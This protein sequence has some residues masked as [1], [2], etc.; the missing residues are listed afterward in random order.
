MTA[1]PKQLKKTKDYSVGGNIYFAT[2]RV[3]QSGQ[4]LCGSSDFGVYEVD[5]TAEKPAPV[6][7]N[8]KHESYVTAIAF[9]ASQ[10]RV[11]SGSYDGRL[12]WWD[13]EKKEFLMSRPAHDKWIRAA[14][15]SPDE[16]LL[17]SVGD[18]MACH[19]WNAT[20]GER[21]HTFRDHSEQTPH[22]YPSMLFAVAFTPDGQFMAT[23]D[24]TGQIVVRDLHSGN[25]ATRL[26][27]PKMY[28][29]DPRARRHSIGGIRSLA[30]SADGKRLAAG[31][32]GKI[33]NIDHLGGPSRIEIFD[34]QAGTRTA[35]I[36]DGQLKGLVE[37]MQFAPDGSW[38]MSAGGDHGGFV[39]FWNA[40]DGKL[41]HQQK[42]PMHV[43]A[44][45]F[46]ESFETLYTVGHD[47]IAVWELKSA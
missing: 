28:T 38:L 22:G 35:E 20:S 4:L 11:I 31:G 41:I 24:K 6:A 17:A 16:K 32:I 26:H 21:L 39:T 44:F 8:R 46:S 45:A 2:A 40:T 15:L 36:E 10:N 19:L 1:Q 9:A 29:W 12:F 3:P 43:H 23:A 7:F 37:Q 30:F 13:R 27:A 47:R 34:W 42:A 18:D 33:G 25:V 5:S 14:A